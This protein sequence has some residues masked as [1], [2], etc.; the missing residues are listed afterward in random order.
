M[1][2]SR[3]SRTRLRPLL[4]GSSFAFG[5]LASLATAS[6]AAGGVTFSVRPANPDPN[7][8]ISRAYFRPVA[9][10]GTSL[11]ET[12]A[13]SDDG[14]APAA[15]FVYPVD[16]LTGVTSGTVYA[17]R[18]DPRTR[19]GTWLTASV[20]SLLLAPHERTTV[21]VRI[22][23]PADATPGDHVAGI[24]FENAHPT[25][26]AG[27]AVT[28]VIREVIG[29]QVRVPGPGQFHLLVDGA[30]FVMPPAVAEPS[31]S[32]R[33]GDDGNRLGQ[34]LLLV[35]LHGPHGFVDSVS[36]Q[37]D[38]LLPGDRISYPL[39]WP[40][41]L[42]PGAYTVS[43]AEDGSSV[44]AFTGPL[45]IPPGATPATSP[46]AVHTAPPSSLAGAASGHRHQAN[47]NGLLVPA[48]VVAGGALILLAGLLQRR[49]HSARPIGAHSAMPV[50]AGWQKSAVGLD[51]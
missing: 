34:S 45:V 51:R 48:I 32:L 31:L 17:N 19:A 49:R 25:S 36:R 37:L 5:V 22:N 7:D 24:A 18:S 33:L 20:P 47:H 35:T 16:G 8:S 41:P 4:L 3:R 26:G 38:T 1:I 44:A 15:L 42:P 9:T 50:A 39:A 40:R 6:A 27:F 43:V 23:V 30:S 28:E 46:S 14:D 21:D 10:P 2:G 12:V 13:V 11:T 29:V